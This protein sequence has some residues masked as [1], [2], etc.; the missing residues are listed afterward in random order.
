VPTPEAD[1][2]VPPVTSEQDASTDA[3]T[4]DAGH[5]ATQS[6]QSRV[7][8][9]LTGCL[10]IVI[11]L[12]LISLLGTCGG[13]DAG[14]GGETTEAVAQREAADDRQYKDEQGEEPTPAEPVESSQTFTKENYAQLVSD[15][16]SYEGAAVDVTGQI[17]GAVEE[18]SNYVYFQMMADPVNYEW[19]T[20]VQAPD[21]ETTL[22]ADDYVHVK[23]TVVGS[24]E[25]EN[26]FGGEVSAV[27]VE[28]DTVEEIQGAEA[29]DPTQESI[30]VNQTASD[31]GF[32]I[33]IQKIEFAA[34]STRVYIAA[35]NDTGQP[36][37]LYTFDA[38]IIQGTTQ[39]DQE[40][41]FD[42][43]LEEP[44]ERLSPGVETQGIVAFGPVDSSQPF[45]VSFEWYSDNFDI[46]PQPI[47]FQVTP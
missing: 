13:G 33:T 27:S 25:G 12:V 19:S 34:N 14:S 3:P 28:A 37:D 36:A 47:V 21:S 5:A 29:V 31:Q 24:M 20:I 22:A 30:E 15:P 46:T 7:P 45:Q 42:Y 18:D 44:Q 1:V 41:P 4:S 39:V 6:R 8:G 17:L 10:V 11:F 16:D 9:V 43:E 23:G 40:M 32:S 35:R 2:A 26:A 38:K